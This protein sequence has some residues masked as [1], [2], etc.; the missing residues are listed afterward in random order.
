MSKNTAGS[1]RT[2]R[3]QFF[4]QNTLPSVKLSRRFTW[5]SGGLDSYYKWSPL[6]LFFSFFT[7]DPPLS[8]FQKSNYNIWLQ[9]L[10]T[11][12]KFKIQIIQ[13]TYSVGWI[14]VGKQIRKQNS[15][16]SWSPTSQL[17]PMPQ[18]SHS[19]CSFS[20]LFSSLVLPLIYY[21]GI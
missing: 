8:L 2:N 12:S 3:R 20:L 6:S 5:V 15:K 17:P 10:I 13:S 7:N 9:N 1:K 16:M 21:F 11:K 14:K 18:P 19:S 4:E